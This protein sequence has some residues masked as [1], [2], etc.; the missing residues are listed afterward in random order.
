M[1]FNIKNTLKSNRNHII[2]QQAS[3]A[4][5]QTGTRINKYIGQF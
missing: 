2:P 5:N 3:A 4:Q 1:H